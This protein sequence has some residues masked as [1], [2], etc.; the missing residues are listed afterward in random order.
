MVSSI[1]RSISSSEMTYESV[2]FSVR[3]KAQNLQYTLQMFV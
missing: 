1:F 2:S 3:Q